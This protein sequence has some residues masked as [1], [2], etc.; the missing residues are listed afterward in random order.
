MD[1]V[2][3]NTTTGNIK[4]KAILKDAP[5]RASYI[6][7]T[8]TNTTKPEKFEFTV[9]FYPQDISRS[10]EKVTF[11]DNSQNIELDWHQ[12]KTLELMNFYKNSFIKIRNIFEKF[13][14]NI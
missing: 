10:P 9:V 2:N 3:V 7:R 13:S 12:E 5:G 14:K 1:A 8:I 4:E 6:Y 11:I